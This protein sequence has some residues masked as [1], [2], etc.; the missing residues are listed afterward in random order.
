MA[1][2]QSPS[3]TGG[4]GVTGEALALG[5]TETDLDGLALGLTEI[6]SEGTG[7]GEVVVTVVVGTSTGTSSSSSEHAARP[8]VM[9]AN[10]DRAAGSFFT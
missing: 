8:N 4:F 2:S 10:T 1:D 3:R 6:D 9:A 7:T 5:L